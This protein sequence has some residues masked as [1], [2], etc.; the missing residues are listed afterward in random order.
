MT[1]SAKLQESFKIAIALAITLL[2]KR[3]NFTFTPG[4]LTTFATA[5]AGSAGT[6]LGF[7]ITAI[8]LM[9]SVMD[10]DLLRNLRATGGYKKL[11]SGSFVC[12]GLHLLLLSIALSLLLPWSGDKV[13]IILAVVFVGSL[14]AVNLAT[15]GLGFYRVIM[16]ISKS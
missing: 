1:I 5:V 14:C 8:A 16:S 9:A 13:T 10:R 3:Y 2:F 7:V 11:I 12:A 4:D 6:I 15:T